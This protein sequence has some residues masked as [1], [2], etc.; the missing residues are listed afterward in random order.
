M[1]SKKDLAIIEQNH[2]RHFK[3]LPR[4]LGF[5]VD[6]IDGLH[7]INC[8]F[9]SSMFNIV[10]GA[11]EGDDSALVITKVKDSFKGQSFAWW[12][13]SNARN[14]ELS[15]TLLEAGLV[16]ET[17]EHAMICDLRDFSCPA[18]KT[19]IAIKEVL[20]SDLLE[21]FIRVLEPYDDSVRDFYKKVNSDHLKSNEKLFVGYAEGRPVTIAILFLSNNSAG[22]F[23]LLTLDDAKSKGYGTD[24]MCYLLDY[25]KQS[26]A[27]NITL[28]ASSDSGYRIY[29]RLGFKK[30]GEFECFEYKDGV[31]QG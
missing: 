15:A 25:A 18:P 17:I 23:S 5:N 19:K 7:L 12:I 8:G 3:F 27:I 21:D 9:G 22:I 1:T 29:E 30:V 26:G 13:P 11:P 4:A 24:M 16:I 14:P 6:E 28:S 2:L 31:K 10:Y 20:D